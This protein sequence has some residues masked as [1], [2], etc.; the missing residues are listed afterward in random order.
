MLALEGQIR[1]RNAVLGVHKNT[2]KTNRHI[3]MHMD[4]KTPNMKKNVS[5]KPIIRTIFKRVKG[6]F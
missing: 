1:S 3:H 2:H 6:L 4:T 5:L